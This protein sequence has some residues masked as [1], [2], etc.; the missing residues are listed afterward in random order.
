ME[1]RQMLHDIIEVAFSDE[2]DKMPF[3]K[4]FFLEFSNKQV[5]SFAGRYFPS[6]KSIEIV[7]LERPTK[8]IIITT[9]H[10]VA[11][12]IDH[13]KRNTTG[14]GPEF[15]AVYEKLIHAALDM[16]IISMNDVNTVC[17]VSDREKIKK[18]LDTYEKSEV[19]YKQNQ[20][21]IAVGNGYSIREQLKMRGYKW[22]TLS[23][24]WKLEGDKTKIDEERL[25]LDSISVKY[26]ISD[27]KD[28]NVKAMGTI[29][30]GQGSFDYK[31]ILKEHGFHYSKE[32]T[33][34][35]TMPFAEMDSQIKKLVEAGLCNVKFKKC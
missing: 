16:G 30:A 22:D 18:M 26:E 2:Q 1:I 25:F 35:K 11:H 29:V 9:L 12:H 19:V 34:K 8:H 3:Y 5:K 21:V 15:Y 23:Q 31:D 6:R 14:H 4:K 32:K 28:Y 33:W 20:F 7:G 17:D 24:V 27:A 13:M 10:E